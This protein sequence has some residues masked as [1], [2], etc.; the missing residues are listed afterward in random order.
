MI[1]TL[2]TI[3]LGGLISFIAFGIGIKGLRFINLGNYSKLE[4][5]VFSIPTCLAIAAL[6][7]FFLGIFELFQPIYI[8][9]WLF[10]LL[11]AALT[12]LK[13]I[14]STISSILKKI[15]NS[16][17]ALNPIHKML[18]G[19]LGIIFILIGL[20]AL[21]PVW[22][23]DGLMYHLEG[24]RRFLSAGRITPL[25]DI[26]QANGPFLIEMLFSIGVAFN[27]TPLAK[28]IHLTYAL[29]LA[30]ATFT[31]GN[32][33]L[34]E[35]KGWIPA[36][37][38]ITTPAFLII[39]SFA[40]ID[41][42]WALYGFLAIYTLLIWHESKNT[43]WLFLSG[44]STGFALGCKYLALGYAAILFL[45]II[46]LSYKQGWK[47]TIKHAFYFGATATLIG[48]PWYIKNLLWT[49]N[50]VYPFFFGGPGWPAERLQMANTYLYSFGTGKGLL[51]F[52]LLPLNLYFN[53]YK[54]T[55]MALIE[56]LNPLFVL[57]LAYPIVRK[58]SSLNILT[59]ITLLGFLLWAIG[60]Q[61]IRF[62]LPLF[63][64]LS[65]LSGYVLVRVA[66]HFPGQR[67]RRILLPGIMGGL[68][69][70]SLITA[71]SYYNAVQPLA[72]L[73]GI[74][75]KSE[76]LSR[77]EGNYSALQYIEG[78]RLPVKQVF[79]IWDGRSFYCDGTCIPDTDNYQ[80]T[81]LVKKYRDISSISNYFKENQ[82]AYL[83]V[84]EQNANF[85][86]EHDPRGE[87][88]AAVR[89]LTQDFI[90]ACAKEVF[91]GDNISVYQFTCS[92]N[93]TVKDL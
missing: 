47:S 26:Y 32:R 5:V 74:E 39:S 24:P 35:K 36:V 91:E 29:I 21:T 67:L 42:A 12:E 71:L 45:L 93:S 83:L 34:G 17:Q 88:L 8:A 58:K 51:D 59:T 4:K 1:L 46:W 78:N 3:L 2:L 72:V 66:H 86:L 11:I 30:A 33:Y 79:M 69:V 77:R 41:I 18:A 52:L 57:A 9:L 68:I 43:N 50:P 82:V 16:W 81:Y 70:F 65:I 63:P 64:G 75:G 76:F 19:V 31:F 23:Y 7:I 84:N 92:G 14:F 48:S 56:K 22:D 20:Q 13:E 55:T 10:V 85:M 60:S 28:I 44:I 6:G 37:I 80:W 62:M 38:L 87:H 49:G 89:F 90:P 73:L 54:F 15:I 53:H 25:E 61:Q 27:I 40:Y